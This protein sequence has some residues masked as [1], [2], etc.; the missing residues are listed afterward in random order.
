[1]TTPL[2][3]TISGQFVRPDNGKASMS[4]Y[5]EA[6]TANSLLTF[7]GGVIAS[8]TPV[9][10]AS[11]GSASV[12]IWQLPQAG[13][14]PSD[15]RWRL[16]MEAGRNRY[17]KEFTLTGD[18]TWDDLVDVSGVPLTSSLVSRA[19]DAAA[20]AEAAEAAVLGATSVTWLGVL[21]VKNPIFGA[22]GDG[23]AD[24]TAA[25][26]AAHAALPSTGGHIYLP[27]GTYKITSALSFT[28]P[29][30]IT[31]AGG[32][33]KG[34]GDVTPPRAL[35]T[36]VVSSAT[37]D[38]LVFS[39]PGVTLADFAVVC[40]AATPTAGTGIK[41]TASHATSHANLRNVTVQGFFDCMA[42]QGVYYT[43]TGCRVY[44]PMRYG[45]YFPN[46]A[47]TNYDDHGDMGLVNCV[48]SMFWTT[49]T[50]NALL[51]WEG[52]GGLRIA[53]SKFNAGQQPYAPTAGQAQKILDI[54]VA[55]GFTTG[56]ILLTGNSFSGGTVSQIALGHSGATGSGILTKITIVGN[57]IGVGYG[58]GVGIQVG[59]DNAHATVLRSVLIA[60]NNF[61][62]L[63]D[64][65]KGGGAVD[66]VIGRNIHTAVTRCLNLDQY[67]GTR[68]TIEPQHMDNGSTQIIYFAARSL[69]QQPSQLDE[70][71]HDY[72]RPVATSTGT[73]AQNRYTVK[74]ANGTTRG[75]SFVLDFEVYGHNDSVGAV[76]AK[77]TR[78]VTF[79]ITPT[80]TVTTVGT[81]TI[82][83]NL[84]VTFTTSTSGVTVVVTATHATNKTING[85]VRIRVRGQVSQVSQT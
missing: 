71:V 77:G 21:S 53:G 13:V 10:L 12:T 59:T 70:V 46:P 50:P 15:A 57:D 24:D 68:R 19:E 75:G 45:Y 73:P 31:G 32:A 33:I 34:D 56:L 18:I 16:V 66:L 49:R 28:K 60:H 29:V 43:L 17:V 65:I 55:D 80:Y 63:V 48:A 83:G 74:G 40:S 4:A 6:A 11:D 1:M 36:L 25:I 72:S 85:E 37:Q 58:T 9:K 51:R 20:T 67:N 2:T 42:F 47:D 76:A 81:D 44:D 82:V 41:M 27:A 5:I 54:A 69:D 39:S 61:G 7:A 52:G 79:D 78:L 22:V 14:D 38:G 3:A 30:T 26:Q 64:S 23:V 35:T 8:K 84:T 62:N